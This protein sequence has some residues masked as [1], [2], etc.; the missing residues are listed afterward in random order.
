MVICQKLP[1]IGTQLQLLTSAG[2]EFQF[3]EASLLQLSTNQKES[4]SALQN[5]SFL[6]EFLPWS[7]QLS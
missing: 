1:V 4:V 3:L 2:G 7:A 5:I 6:L